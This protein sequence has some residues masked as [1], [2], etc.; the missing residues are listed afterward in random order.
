M[1]Y[2][3]RRLM[4]SL[5]IGNLVASVLLV[6]ASPDAYAQCGDWKLVSTPNVGNSVTR[7]TALTS[8][9]P[10]D[11][12]AVGLW[13]ND[14]A[15]S[16][17]VAMRWDGF[18][19]S[20]VDLPDTGQLGTMPQTEGIDAAPNGDVWLV[21]YVTT[22]YP[23][24]NL[25]LVLRWRQGAWEQVATVT[26]RPQT[27]YPFAARGGFAYEV[28]AIT[29]DDVWAVGAAVG[30]GDGGATSVPLAMHWDG[31]SWTDV[32][33]P[34][35][36]NR[37]HELGDLVAI[38][39]DDVWAVGDYRNVSGTFRGVTYHWDGS[40]WSHIPSP[41]EELSQ[42]GLEDIVATGP[43]D[44]WAIGGAPDT[45]VVLMHWDGSQ[46][47]LAQPPANSGG[48]LAAVGTNDL[49]ASGWNGF[50]H[51]DGA[52]W[53]ETPTQVP[54]ASYMLR[55]GG[56]EIVGN[57]DIWSAG[58]WTLTD[59]IT[60]FTLAERIQTISSSVGDTPPAESKLVFA[61]PFHRMGA[62][63]VRVASQARVHLSIYDV[64]GTKV[65]DLLG[66]VVMQGDGSIVW[67]GLANSGQ[68]VPDG[69]YFLRLDAGGQTITRKL[70]LIRP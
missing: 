49:W 13:R 53:T 19:W 48:S 15:G 69:V 10:N 25:P 14:P 41:I 32:E 30:Y 21:G 63:H 36:A 51:W 28:D 20:L 40:S 17:P 34:R 62:I 61:N 1:T 68:N 26:L 59:G 65:R 39:H 35:V 52:S 43:D 47:S 31:S 5:A 16:G 46:W 66:P 23:T 44:V 70:V 22:T 2:T 58:F 64:R 50:W 3:K 24:N 45:G 57:C 4:T 7:L 60:S 67:D 8:L 6:A 37:H 42:S 29:D 11:A 38:S 9:A 27:V 18:A 56:M 54:G 33:V 55:S 12:W